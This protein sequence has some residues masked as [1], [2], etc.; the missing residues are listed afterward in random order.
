[1]KTNV[2]CLR[3]NLD[4]G[5]KKDR[6]YQKLMRRSSIHSQKCTWS[7]LFRLTDITKRK[8]FIKKTKTIQNTI[9]LNYYYSIY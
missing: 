4:T 5:C 8:Q 7:I 9:D 2:N 6:N 1:M 3:N